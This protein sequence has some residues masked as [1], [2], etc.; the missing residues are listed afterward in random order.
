VKAQR[1]AC[2]YR[3]KKKAVQLVEKSDDNEDGN[4]RGRKRSKKS[5]HC[6][7]CK[8]V[9][10][11]QKF[12]SKE[13]VGFRYENGHLHAKQDD[14]GN[15]SI[16]E[17]NLCI[18]VT[19]PNAKMVML[20]EKSILEY[21]PLDE[22]CKVP[23]AELP[24]TSSNSGQSWK[25]FGRRL[26]VKVGDRLSF[27]N[28][29]GRSA[30]LEHFNHFTA[31]TFIVCDGN[32][33][34]TVSKSLEEKD[35]DAF[36]SQ[37]MTPMLEMPQISYSQTQTDHSCSSARANFSIL[38]QTDSIEQFH[39]VQKN[40]DE[41]LDLRLFSSLTI[42]EVKDIREQLKPSTWKHAL[43]SIVLKKSEN[44]SLRNNEKLVVVPSLLS[45]AKIK[46]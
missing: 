20:N 16:E 15:N 26:P 10:L 3:C 9:K 44:E 7:Y 43:L 25:G 46:S 8:N 35:D 21:F 45:E 30:S 27:V 11:A 32:S 33:F 23:M 13:L 36:V 39:D 12:L 1:A 28:L 31:L 17:V 19:G 2:P 42:G 6:L 41:D 4:C 29:D 22:E 34:K 24:P 5:I 18:Y 40:D 14:Q 37:N 38:D